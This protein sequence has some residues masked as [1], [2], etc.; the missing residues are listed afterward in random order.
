MTKEEFKTRWES[1]NDGGG[2]TFDDI[3]KCAVKWGINSRPKTS[4]IDKVMYAVL[5]AAGTNDCEEYK[6]EQQ[7]QPC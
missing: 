5:K 3:A 6:P 2:I 4:P 7:N 1:S